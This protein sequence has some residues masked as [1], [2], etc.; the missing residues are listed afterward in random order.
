MN[1]KITIEKLERGR[2]IKHK[3]GTRDSILRLLKMGTTRKLISERLGIPL[4]TVYWV[5]KK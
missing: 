3:K 4:R 1:I 5:E 2:P